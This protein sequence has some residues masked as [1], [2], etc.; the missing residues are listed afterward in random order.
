M[1]LFRFQEAATD[2]APIIEDHGVLKELF[3]DSGQKIMINNDH[4]KCIIFFFDADDRS[5]AC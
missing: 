3:Q 2:L 5:Y 4:S 1:D